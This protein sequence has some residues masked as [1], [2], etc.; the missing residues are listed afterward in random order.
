MQKILFVCTGN[1]CRSAM[2]EQIAN[3]L[4]GQRGLDLEFDSAGVSD[5][6]HGNPMDSRA[7]RVMKQ[8]GYPV[9]PHQA[10]QVSRRML[11]EADLAIGF[12]NA[13]VSRMKRIAP[14]ANIRLMTDFDPEAVPG[15]DISDP[16]YGGP[17]EFEIA[18]CEIESALKG[19]LEEIV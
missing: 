16:W 14:D 11:D 7:V 5:E 2:A 12:T 8:H 13:H 18:I 15:A 4:S 6:E 19:M 17:E 1:I 3:Y 9:S 10:K